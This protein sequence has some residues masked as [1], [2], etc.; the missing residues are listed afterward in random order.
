MVVMFP[1]TDLNVPPFL[2]GSDV[3]RPNTDL[4]VPPLK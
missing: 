1:N 4:N 2:N 3:V